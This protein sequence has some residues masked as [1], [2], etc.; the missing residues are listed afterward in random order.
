MSLPKAMK[1][2]I[3]TGYG[4][5]DRVRI[6]TRPVPVPKKDEVLIEV[7]ATTVNSGDVRMRAPDAPAGMG[8]LMR[9]VIGLT[10]PRQP[11]FGVEAAGRIVAMGAAVEGF[12]L[13][14]EVIA[15]PGFSMGCHA[16]YVAVKQN[17]PIVAKPADLSFAQAVGLCFGGTTAMEFLR[18]AGLAKGD[19]ILVVGASGAVGTAMVQL[20]KRAGARVTAVTSAVNADLV[21]RLGADAVIDYAATNWTEA[22]AD[23]DVIADTVGASS[24][25]KCLGALRPDGRY[26]AIA[27]G[28]PDM[29]A[30]RK[31]DKRSIS[32]M[33]TV[34]KDDIELLAGLAAK[35]QYRVVIDQMFDLKDIAKAHARVS[36]KRKR[37]SVVVRVGD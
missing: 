8:L 27:G 13:G 6:E 29:L 19:H 24:F 16:Q 36:S 26:L 32:G 7:V 33:V 12:T 9:L 14:D 1:A 30:R 15:A 4:G 35:G 18:K 20:A 3:V 34:R 10:R 25:S 23:Y 31:G 37:G 11:V 22:I 2:A 21:R 17:A 5:P 28:I